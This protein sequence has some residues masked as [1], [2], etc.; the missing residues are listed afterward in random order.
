[1][2][3]REAGSTSWATTRTR[4]WS[5]SLSNASAISLDTPQTFLCHGRNDEVVPV[6]N[7]LDYARALSGHK[8]PFELYVPDNGPH[9][10]G[11]GQEGS[12]THWPPLCQ[13]WLQ[14][15]KILG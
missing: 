13:R 1:M 12:V 8:I 3:T 2:P 9:G 7:S 6:E 10:F 11:L 15:R 4:S 5:K 14:Q